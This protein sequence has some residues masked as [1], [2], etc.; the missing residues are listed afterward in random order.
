[1]IRHSSILGAAIV[2]IV[3]LPAAASGQETQQ[4]QSTSIGEGARAPDARRAVAVRIQGDPPKVDGVLDEPIWQVAPPITH[5]RQRNPDEGLEMTE[6]TAVRFAYTDDDLYVAFRGYDSDPSKVYGRLVR[7]DQR[8]AADYFSLFIDSYHDRRQAYEFSINPSG[9]RRDVFI[10]NDGRGRDDSWDP[11]YDWKTR[12]DSL[13]WTVEMRIP[14]SQLRFPQSDS[15]TFGIRVRRSINRRNEEASWPYFPR[16]IAGEVSQYGDL[17]GLVQIPSPRQVEFLPY[18]AGSASF[19]PAEPGNPFLADGRASAVRVGVDLKLGVTSGLTIDATVNPDFGQVEADA[20]VVNLSA[21]ETFFPEKRPFFIEGTNLFQF[22]L[23][24][25]QGGFRFGGFGRGAQEGLVYTRRIGRSPQ[26]SPDDQ[27]GYAED[28]TQTTI[29]GAAKMSGQVG[30]GWQVGVMQAVT[31]KEYAKVVDSV[32]ARARS[33]IEPLTSH[34]VLR[35]QRSVSGG[36]L[37]YGALATGLVRDLD[38]SVFDNLHR[39]AFSGGADFYARFGRNQYEVQ[40]AASGSRVE[41]STDA[42]ASTQT[43]SARYYQRPDNDHTEFDSTRTSLSGFAGYAEIAKVTGFFTWKG[44]YQTRSPGFETNDM[45]FLRRADVHD[46]RAEVELRW[47]EPGDVFRQFEWRFTERAE[48]TYGGERTRTSLATRLDGDF[49]NYWN[50]TLSAERQ[51]ESFDV[52]LLRG[53][54]AFVVPGGWD[55]GLNGRTDFRRQVQVSAGVNRSVEDLSGATGWRANVRLGLRPPGQFGISFDVRASWN[56]N[57]HQYIGQESTT[58][59]TYYVLG[60]LDRRQVSLTMRADI[61]LTPRLSL[62]LYAQ[63][64]VSAGTYS[65]LRLAADPRAADYGGRMDELESDR[66]TRPGGGVDVEVDVD[67][68]GTVDFTFSDPDFRVASLRTNAVLRWEFRPGST[69]FL[70]WQQDR[71]DVSDTGYGGGLGGGLSDAIS[72]P[73]TQIFAIKVAYWIGT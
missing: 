16:D 38:E 8:T 53:G 28:V 27:G 31:S 14:F 56:T 18:T 46:Q 34:T 62:E 10:Y 60:R 6:R 61:A 22:G 52:G 26:V 48:F 11:V 23:Q 71:R 20:A 4:S 59:S 24:P 54:P 51:L 41:G 21:F 9:A 55:I 67:R 57:D 5:F 68:D 37:S 42:I 44:R 70:V 30:G 35:V 33:A 15:V 72:A 25:S 1:M 50:L 66:L 13:G 2:A 36:R 63:P 49:L 19:Q 43:R 47:L 58:D 40:L 3:G 45:G 12:T 29:L 7:R 65:P 32:G 69:L 73:G 17:V 64:F 39:R